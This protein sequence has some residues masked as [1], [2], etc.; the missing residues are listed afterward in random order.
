ML[1]VPTLIICVIIFLQACNDDPPIP[2]KIFMRVYVDILIAQD[3]TTTTSF[4]TDSL[5]EEILADNDILPEQYVDMIEYYNARPEKWMPF[6]D[7]VT[8]YVEQMRLESEPQL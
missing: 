6:F 5:R 4:S 3:T 1:K 7:S 8:V 2:E